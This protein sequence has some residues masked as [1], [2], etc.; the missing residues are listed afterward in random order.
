V[1][2]GAVIGAACNIGDH[3]Y[4]EG[5]ARIGDRVTVKNAVLVWDKVTIGDD[6]FVGPSATFT[7]DMV[8]RAWTSDWQV[9]PTRVEHQASIGANATIVCGVT[10]G[11][12]AM[13]AAGAVVTN[14]VP[15]FALVMGV[16]ARVVDYVTVSGRR[17]H[18]DPNDTP[19]LEMVEDER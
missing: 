4:V 15:P 12:G 19:S 13:V 9:V 7:N 8:P 1:L 6:V 3:A 17:L 5:G 18:L 11:R 10:I 16:P 14:D 2:P